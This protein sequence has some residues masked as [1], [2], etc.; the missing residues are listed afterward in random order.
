MIFFPLRLSK[1]Q[2]LAPVKMKRQSPPRAGRIWVEMEGQLA[3]L[4][5]SD[6]AAQC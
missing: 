6:G 3:A 2:L 5:S 1:I 4:D